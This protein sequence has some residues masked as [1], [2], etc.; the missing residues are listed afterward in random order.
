MTPEARDDRLLGHGGNNA[1]RAVSAQG[2]GGHVQ[3]KHAPQEPGPA[4]A[5]CARLRR[6]PIHTLLA[7]RWDHRLAQR[8]VRRQTPRLADE[9]DARQRDERRQLL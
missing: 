9:G 3:R 5:G 4:P 2:P 7:R 6:I 8:A 1:E